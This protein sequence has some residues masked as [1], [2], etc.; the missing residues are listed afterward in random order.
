MNNVGET[1]LYNIPNPA[2]EKADFSGCPPEF[3]EDATAY[4]DKMKQLSNNFAIASA[5]ALELPRDYFLKSLQ[6]FNNTIARLLYY[7]PCDY[8]DGTSSGDDISGSIRSGEHTDFG[9]FTFLFCD[10][11][12]LQVKAVEGGEIGGAAGGELTG[13]WLDVPVPT[14]TTVIVNTGALMARWTNDVWRATAHRVIV[15]NQL[16]AMSHRFSVA[17]FVEPDAGVLVEVHPCFVKEGEK[18]K[19]EPITSSDYLMS[20]LAEIRPN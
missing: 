14:G 10:G 8:A 17:F 19:Y 5:I 1:Q 20:K 4:W 13:A 12:G 15:S 6:E 7:P 16:Q 18:P 2:G 9:M 11:P 3:R